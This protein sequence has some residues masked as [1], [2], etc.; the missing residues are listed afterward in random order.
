MNIRCLLNQC[1]CVSQLTFYILDTIS[2]IT[3]LP[4]LSHSTNY[5]PSPIFFPLYLSLINI[6]IS[7]RYAMS[8]LLLRLTPLSLSL[9]FIH[10]LCSPFLCLHY[11]YFSFISHSL[12]LFHFLSLSLLL[13]CSLYFL[14]PTLLLLFCF[15]YYSL[16]VIHLCKFP[17]LL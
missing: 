16:S 7:L 6:Y 8:F 11:N 2:T 17:S 10:P 13:Y 3:L 12:F 1:N 5:S 14:P 9:S 15:D 4:L